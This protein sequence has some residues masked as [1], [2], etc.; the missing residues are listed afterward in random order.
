MLHEKPTNREI[1][2]PL[3]PSIGLVEDPALGCSGPLWVRG[4]IPIE[5]A[6]GKRYERRNRVTLCRC[7]ASTNKPFCNGSH[8]SIEFNDGLTAFTR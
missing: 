3:A 4:G 5:S 7:G 1:E 8:A 6:D 2:D